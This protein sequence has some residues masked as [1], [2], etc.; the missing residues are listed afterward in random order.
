MKV[1]IFLLSLI[2]FFSVHAQNDDCNIISVNEYGSVGLIN[3]YP[4]MEIEL[5]ADNVKLNGTYYSAN[6]SIYEKG[7]SFNFSTPSTG[8]VVL[9]VNFKEGRGQFK[10]KY[11]NERLNFTFVV[12][13]VKER[14]ILEEKKRLDAIKREKIFKEKNKALLEKLKLTHQKYYDKSY[15]GHKF[16]YD[17]LLEI[18]KL[19]DVIDTLN[20]TPDWYKSDVID[21][22]LKRA[23]VEAT[24]GS[25]TRFSN[26][27]D[28]LE[29]Y[30]NSSVG[31]EFLES[32]DVRRSNLEAVHSICRMDKE[33]QRVS[34]LFS[35]SINKDINLVLNV[36]LARNDTAS[37]I[38]WY[39]DLEGK[40]YKNSIHRYVYGYLQKVEGAT[41]P[42]IRGVTAIASEGIGMNENDR[43][44][45]DRFK[46]E[47]EQYIKTY[48]FYWNFNFNSLKYW[49][50]T[51]RSP[52]FKKLI[53]VRKNLK[54]YFDFSVDIGINGEP[55]VK[56]ENLR[57]VNS[58]GQSEILVNGPELDSVY[59][60]SSDFN[61]Q[62]VFKKYLLEYRGYHIPQRF[63]GSVV[64][65]I[66]GVDNVGKISLNSNGNWSVKGN[67]YYT[68][69]NMYYFSG[70]NYWDYW[71]W[72]GSG[73]NNNNRTVITDVVTTYLL[74]HS[75][76]KGFWNV[77]WLRL[78]GGFGRDYYRFT[79]S[80]GQQYVFR[81]RYNG[82][83][84]AS[85]WKGEGVIEVLENGNFVL[86]KKFDANTLESVT[87]YGKKGFKKLWS[88]LT[89]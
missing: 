61:H 68:G 31:T 2:A 38:S 17:D 72:L 14:L 9:I 53:K 55:K 87:N 35:E 49:S 43:Y 50:V 15:S 82:D 32:I 25:V 88:I 42:W 77:N 64:M 44:W 79:N 67:K 52:E 78:G 46:G 47:R 22:F 12:I 84:T 86:L 23:Y 51:S 11:E 28:S 10:L 65:D 80:K 81:I 54:L 20:F 4:G 59:Y 57:Y 60:V 83:Y 16:S 21:W 6:Y 63:S 85:F 41:I 1:W 58:D 56:L 18:R 8:E 26:E 62:E 70:N 39:R 48:L 76:F 29:L 7:M 71:G 37:F 3:F 19:K 5:C 89:Q 75:D 27:K 66:Q 73:V 13:D 36:F 24:E 30:S 45:Y 69:D 34:N 40:G 33:Y 74:S